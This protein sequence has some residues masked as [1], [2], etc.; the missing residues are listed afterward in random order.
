MILY[1]VYKNKGVNKKLPE[2]DTKMSEINEVRIPEK[3]TKGL[4]EPNEQAIDVAKLN[5][6]LRPPVV[7]TPYN[8]GIEAAPRAVEC[9]A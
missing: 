9:Q 5:T 3:K 7:N 6:M 4:N 1:F 2:I 8:N